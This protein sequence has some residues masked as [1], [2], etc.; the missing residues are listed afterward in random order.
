VGYAFK[1]KRINLQFPSQKQ[2]CYYIHSA[3]R[4][5]GTLVSNP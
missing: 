5:L 3:S 1:A 4:I 2:T